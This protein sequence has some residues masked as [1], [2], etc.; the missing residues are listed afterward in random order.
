MSKP[1]LNPPIPPD[2]SEPLKKGLLK[3]RLER[4]LDNEKKRCYVTQEKE[5]CDGSVRL[6]GGAVCSLCG[7]KGKV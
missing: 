2:E 6:Q 7:K 5:R 1:P 3:G 4:N